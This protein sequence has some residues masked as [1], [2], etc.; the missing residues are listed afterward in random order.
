MPRTLA[1]FTWLAMVACSPLRNVSPSNLA[2]TRPAPPANVQ[3]TVLQLAIRAAIGPDSSTSPRRVLLQPPPS[4]DPSRVLPTLSGVT[5]VTRDSRGFQDLAD[6]AGLIT[7]WVVDAP[8]I[9]G[10]SAE[11]VISENPIQPRGA[12]IPG[13]GGGCTYILN[14]SNHGWRVAKVVQ[15][16][17]EG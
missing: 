14:R 15:C 6:R 13:W 12:P 3:D 10:D 2:F 9:Y 11:V 16:I 8:H 1:T 4:I 7:V 17:Y 5:F